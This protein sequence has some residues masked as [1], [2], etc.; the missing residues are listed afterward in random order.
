MQLPGGAPEDDIAVRFTRAFEKLVRQLRE[1]AADG[2]MSP[3]AASALARLSETG[4]QRI[5]DLAH[6]ENVSQPAMTQLVD[7]MVKEGLASRAESGTDRRA[8]LVDVTVAG[9]AALAERHSARV[10]RMDI[11]L[12]A[13]PSADRALLAAAVPA[14]E[15]L[16][17]IASEV[18][19]DVG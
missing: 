2:R 3:A 18:T 8:V 9:K 4:P 1:A 12:A 19:T 13:L 14:L 15:R 10:T 7:R 6:R 11:L 16:V 5:T 17:E